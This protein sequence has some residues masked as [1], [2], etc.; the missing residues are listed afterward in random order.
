MDKLVMRS[1][2]PAEWCEKV[3][4]EEE[5]K[6]SSVKAAISS[7]PIRRMA[8]SAGEHRKQ[9]GEVRTLGVPAHA[10]AV[11][12]ASR[13]GYDVL[14]RARQTHAGDVLDAVDAED[15]SVEHGGP[16]GAIGG[17][18]TANRRLAELVVGDFEGDVGTAKGG[19]G[20]SQ[21]LLDELG[22][23]VDLRAVDLDTLDGREGAGALPEHAGLGQLFD[24]LG[25]V[26]SAHFAE[27]RVRT[28]PRN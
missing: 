9:W 4:G 23:D 8:A 15:G 1:A 14:E 27:R 28:G 19:A 16:K 26:R 20:E 17:G 5:G 22:V 6:N 12:K 3:S 10:H 11:D 24:D 21:L 13:E 2:R 7:R 25:G 18:G